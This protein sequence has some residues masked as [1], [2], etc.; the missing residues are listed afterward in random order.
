LET[1]N[2]S[3]IEEGLNN[4]EMNCVYELKNLIVK[5]EG[6]RHGSSG[7]LL[8]SKHKF[9]PHYQQQQQKVS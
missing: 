8:S 2:I 4:R 9:K 3:E 7:K 6:C 5:N 1:Q